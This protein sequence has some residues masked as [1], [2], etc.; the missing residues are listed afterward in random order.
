MRGVEH[1]ADDLVARRGRVNG[2]QALRLDPLSVSPFAARL[3]VPPAVSAASRAG[4]QGGPSSV[5][6]GGS[7]TQGGHFRRS[8]GK[9]GPK[10]PGCEVSPPA[11]ACPDARNEQASGAPRLSKSGRGDPGPKARGR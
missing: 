7:W 4:A 9:N 11:L 1:L 2:R 8:S 6:H 5:S 3:I 10:G